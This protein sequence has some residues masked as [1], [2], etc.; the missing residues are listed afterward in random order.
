MDALVALNA[1]TNWRDKLARLVQYGSRLSWFVLQKNLNVSPHIVAKLQSLEFTASLFR[2]TLR[3]G[4]CVDSFYIAF[5]AIQKKQNLLEFLACM[6]KI[7]YSMFLLC[8][9]ITWFTRVGLIEFNTEYWGEVSNKYWLYSIFLA[10]L[11]NL[12]N[13]QSIH[14]NTLTPLN[15]KCLMTILNAHKALFLDTLRNLCDLIIPLSSLGAVRLNAGLVGI[16]GIISSLASLYVIS[17]SLN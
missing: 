13:I 8:D 3:L 5:R 4:L 17:D 14:C 16:L 2:K 1:K 15:L 9:H 12:L 7:S 6:S 10:F 11:R